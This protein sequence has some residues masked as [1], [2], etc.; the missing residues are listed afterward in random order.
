MLTSLWT[1]LALL[2]LLFPLGPLFGARLKLA[3][4]DRRARPG[5][6]SLFLL[7]IDPVRAYYGASLFLTQAAPWREWS[8]ADGYG[9]E[10]VIAAFFG[11]TLAA[12]TFGR[13]TPDYVLAPLGF[14]AGL[15]IALLNPVAATFSLILAFSAAWAFRAW[16]ASFLV[17]ALAIAGI[18]FALMSEDRIQ[19]ALFGI[20]CAGPALISL[21]LARQMALP[22]Q[23]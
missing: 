12:Q 1:W 17:G 8:F 6:R 18:G 3:P 20:L 15:V 16:A 22:R 14:M 4:F 13:M 7:L 19:T 5:L 2:L 11:A 10:L 9:G 23:G 21:M